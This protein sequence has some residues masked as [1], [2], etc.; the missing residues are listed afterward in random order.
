[1][2]YSSHQGGIMAPM[3]HNRAYTK[4]LLLSVAARSCGRSL[5]PL[6][7]CPAFKLGASLQFEQITRLPHT[8]WS[9]QTMSPFS[10]HSC[11]LSLV[12][13]NLTFSP[14][15]HGV[16][17]SLCNIKENLFNIVEINWI[18]WSHVLLQQL[19]NTIKGKLLWMNWRWFCFHRTLICNW[20]LAIQSNWWLCNRKK[21][22]SPV[23]KNLIE[24]K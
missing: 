24:G 7:W 15:T 16:Y 20:Q 14:Q 18:N 4:L 2:L 10:C 17:I 9:G 1:M 11:P 8:C 19:D 13:Y 3:A 6:S 5:S 22:K 23:S 21:G 12:R